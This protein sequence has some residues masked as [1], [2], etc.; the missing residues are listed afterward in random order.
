MINVE[1]KFGSPLKEWDRRV[2]R[3]VEAHYES[4]KKLRRNHYILG[5]VALVIVILMGALKDLKTNEDYKP[6]C[7]AIF[8]VISVVATILVSFQTFLNYGQRAEKHREAASKY[9]S[10]RRQ[11]EYLAKKEFSTE[12]ALQETIEKLTKTIDSLS[13]STPEVLSKVW[14]SVRKKY[15]KNTYKSKLFDK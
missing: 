4:A 14:S 12:D 5:I 15:D 10:V 8:Y 11:I 6:L 2:S 9:G 7:S 1:D 13:E 3:A